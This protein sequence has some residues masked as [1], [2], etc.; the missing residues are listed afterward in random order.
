[1]QWK[2]THDSETLKGSEVRRGD[3]KK[4]K[5]MRQHLIICEKTA[6]T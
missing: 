5:E 4:V 6:T 1:M 2:M 3:G